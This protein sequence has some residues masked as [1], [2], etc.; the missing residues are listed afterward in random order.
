MNLEV[1]NFKEHGDM[2]NL[3]RKEDS[4]NSLSMSKEEEDYEVLPVSELPLLVEQRVG[5]VE[6]CIYYVWP[7]G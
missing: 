7:Q 1:F 3:Q 5:S 6:F 4:N 2:C